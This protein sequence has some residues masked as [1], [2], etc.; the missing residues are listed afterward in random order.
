MTFIGNTDSGTSGSSHKIDETYVERPEVTDPKENNDYLLEQAHVKDSMNNRTVVN[1]DIQRDLRAHLATFGKGAR[2][3]VTYYQR[4]NIEDDSNAVSA[5]ADFELDDVHFGYKKINAF[6]LKLQGDIEFEYEAGTGF[7]KQTG[8]AVVLPGF[9]AYIGDIFLYEVDYGQYG[10]FIV[11]ESERLA[12]NNFSHH[13]ISFTLK[14]IPSNA[15]IE[16]LNSRVDKVLYFSRER[17]LD[18]RA[19]VLES[20]E[21]VLVSRLQELFFMAAEVFRRRYF[22]TTRVRAFM[23]NDEIYDG[24]M[25]RFLSRA[26]DYHDLEMRPS[27]YTE[28]ID[29]SVVTIL[30]AILDPDLY[31]ISTIDQMFRYAHA[32]KHCLST[33]ITGITN[34]KIVL[35]ESSDGIPATPYIFRKEFYEG[36]TT[37]FGTYESI[38]YNYV[39]HGTTD[40][41]RV[42]ALLQ[43]A[44]RT[45]NESTFYALPIM[46]YIAKIAM[47][48]IGRDEADPIKPFTGVT[49]V[50]AIP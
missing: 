36:D 1:M 12:F 11:T 3:A 43:Q 28:A 46:M 23:E 19:A 49:I 40:S 32:E 13:L 18:G 27:V 8:K 16:K 44:I 15:L 5:T 34:T 14:T 33:T 21:Y 9:T 6:E 26:F 4:N 31:Q 38:I 37:K 17:A 29:P 20:D 48:R 30:D 7:S 35:F 25:A 22:K 50:P 42:G 47:T 10:L 39:M 45:R 24:Y 2:I 41:V